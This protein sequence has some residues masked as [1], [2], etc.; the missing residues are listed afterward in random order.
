MP[1]RG[2]YSYNYIV[3]SLVVVTIRS[4]SPIVACLVV[5]AVRT[6]TI[7]RRLVVMMRVVPQWPVTTR[8]VASH[9]A[10][11]A[12]RS[13]RWSTSDRRSTG[14]RAGMSW[15]TCQLASTRWRLTTSATTRPPSSTAPH[16]SRRRRIPWW[17]SISDRS[18]VCLRPLHLRPL[19]CLPQTAPP[20]TALMSASD[21]STSDRSDSRL[22][23]SVCLKPSKLSI[24]NAMKG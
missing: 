14:R 10:R 4:C 16:A 22:S 19:W 24:S 5:M 20:Q 1:C 3:A 17:R 8:W 13:R 12:G 9:A 18:D 23:Q 21:R 2:G 11:W 15:S 6:A 7:Y